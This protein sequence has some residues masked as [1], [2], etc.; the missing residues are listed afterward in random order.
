MLR[1][2]SEPGE[3][4]DLSEQW[5]HLPEVVWS[6]ADLGFPRVLSFP[7]CEIVMVMS[8]WGFC[9]DWRGC[10]QNPGG[11]VGVMLVISGAMAR[12]TGAGAPSLGHTPALPPPSL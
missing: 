4:G 9:G 7:I 12:R 2:Y 11:G 10:A 1:G 8:P 6:W 3:R 5:G